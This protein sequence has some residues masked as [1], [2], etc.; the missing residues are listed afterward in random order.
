MEDFEQPSKKK[1]QEDT[2]MVNENSEKG[3]TEKIR[4]NPWIVTT[5][6]LG[7]F[8]LVLIIINFTGSNITGG[9][10]GVNDAGANL[11][12]FANQQGINAELVG[13][14]DIGNFYEVTLS[15]NG[16]DVPVM[17]TKDG[18]YLVQGLTPLSLEDSEV[19]E[20]A[21]AEIP[22]SD[23]PKVE[24]FVM[25]HCPYGTQA[26][27]GIIPVIET[28][29]NTIDAKIRFVHYFMH[30]PEKTET[31]TQVCIREE[32]PEKFLPYLKCFLEDGN[33]E[34]CIAK[35]G[36][37]KIKINSCI[38]NGKAEEYYAADSELSQSYGVGGS[39][40]LIV[41]GVQSNAGRDSQS[42]LEGICS[43]FNIAPELCS[44]E[45][46][47]ASPSPGFGYSTSGTSETDDAQC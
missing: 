29:G 6:V 19:E 1:I 11:L 16:N 14:E 22:K 33:S 36:I 46:P 31:P 41:N 30:D 20:T 15:I 17:I 32:Q 18:K 4:A 43:A 3:V 47:S 5:V 25:T 12:N 26:E 23:K 8:S 21:S 13:S 27:K 39:P 24:L 42:Y 44:A 38:S 35:L 9:T 2:E 10:I 34:R 7:I 40:T 28:L 37:S 45:L